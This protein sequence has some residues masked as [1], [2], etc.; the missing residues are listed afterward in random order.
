MITIMTERMKYLGYFFKWSST[1]AAKEK[2]TF[3]EFLSLWKQ[4]LS[5]FGASQT[6]KFKK[7]RRLESAYLH[8]H[9]TRFYLNFDLWP[10]LSRKKIAVKNSVDTGLSNDSVVT[11]CQI[12]IFCHGTI[13]CKICSFFG[14]VWK[15]NTNFSR[16]ILD[17]YFSVYG[18]NCCYYFDNFGFYPISMDYYSIYNLDNLWLEYAIY[19]WTKERESVRSLIF[20]SLRIHLVRQV[21]HTLQ[22]QEPL[23]N[24]TAFCLK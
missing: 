23:K 8:F 7:I 2:F 10:F 6:N 21:V 3:T 24:S 4:S 17:N 1:Q 14:T 22:I 16:F 15:K 12:L 9:E 11:I 18:F 20:A 5:S 19:R 13:W